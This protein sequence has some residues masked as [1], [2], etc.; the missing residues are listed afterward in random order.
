MKRIKDMVEVK[1]IPEDN[2]WRVELYHIRGL[3]KTRIDLKSSFGDPHFLNKEFAKAAADEKIR[4]IKAS[5]EA[6]RKR[7]EQTVSYVVEIDS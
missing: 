4:E 3:S 7:R 1:I 2:M 5:R 6:E